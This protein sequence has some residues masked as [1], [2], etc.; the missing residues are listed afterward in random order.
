[1]IP[2]YFTDKKER[3]LQQCAQMGFDLYQCQD[4]LEQRGICEMQMNNL[5]DNLNNPQYVNVLKP[6]P[7]MQAMPQAS[8]MMNMMGNAMM[9]NVNAAMQGGQPVM[10]AAPQG[11]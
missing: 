9:G 8:P 11:Q 4:F 6:M 2:K 7:M 5:V 10:M 3:F 1:M